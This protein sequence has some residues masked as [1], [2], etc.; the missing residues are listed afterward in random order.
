ML[1]HRGGPNLHITPWPMLPMR[2]AL[3]SRV[4]Q[5]AA[6][7]CFRR[8]S[9]TSSP[10]ASLDRFEPRHNGPRKADLPEMLATIGVDSLE[11]LTKKT[12]PSQILLDRALDLGKYSP[13]L[14]EY[15]P[16]HE[17]R[18]LL[19]ATAC[20]LPVHPPR[21]SGLKLLLFL[22]RVVL[23]TRLAGR[24]HWWSS[25]ASPRAIRLRARSS[26]WG[27][28]QASSVRLSLS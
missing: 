23:G 22:S 13:G 3:R 17:M 2:S 7:L 8:H 16:A 28:L 14:S 4:P 6:A 26:A 5:R 11:D 15:A 24:T 1:Q 19:F 18:I 10:L 20:S 12:V 21:C 9:S 27:M 25:S